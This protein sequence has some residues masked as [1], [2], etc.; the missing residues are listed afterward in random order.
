MTDTIGFGNLKIVSTGGGEYN[1]VPLYALPRDLDDLRKAI[2]PYQDVE[3]WEVEGPH[4]NAPSPRHLL[5]WVSLKDGTP[6]HILTALVKFV[7][8]MGGFNFARFAE[9]EFP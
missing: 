6:W 7:S 1:Q 2:K 4:K 3:I 5:I 8:D 9:N